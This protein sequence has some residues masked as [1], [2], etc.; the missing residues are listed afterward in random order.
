MQHTLIEFAD[1][2]KDIIDT[3]SWAHK[4]NLFIVTNSMSRLSISLFQ[5]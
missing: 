1:D 4:D 3:V 2:T 5:T